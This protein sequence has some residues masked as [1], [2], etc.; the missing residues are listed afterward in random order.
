MEINFDCKVGELIKQLPKEASCETLV[1]V[2]LAM[3]E[4]TKM[5]AD[6]LPF[7]KVVKLYSKSLSALLEADCKDVFSQKSMEL[8]N[9]EL[10]EKCD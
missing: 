4:R 9:K 5:I 2:F 1:V 7:P 3:Q 6:F 10:N 8:I